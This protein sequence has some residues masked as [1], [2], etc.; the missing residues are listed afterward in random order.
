M[1]TR[2]FSTQPI[3]R[4]DRLAL[5]LLG[6]NNLSRRHILSKRNPEKTCAAVGAAK[7]PHT[8]RR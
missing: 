8:Q 4:F 3:F 1:K 5:R 2:R 7:R 6:D